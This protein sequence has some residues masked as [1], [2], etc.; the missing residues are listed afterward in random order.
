MTKLPRG[1]MVLLAL[2]TL[3]PTT[4]ASTLVLKSGGRISGEITHTPD[5]TRRVFE[6]KTSSGAV[7][8][9]AE[10]KVREV[11]DPK[12]ALPQYEEWLTKMP[13]TAAGNWKM[14]DLCKQN[15]LSEERLHH[16]RKVIELDPEH[17]EARFLLG[18]KK[19][20]NGVWENPDEQWTSMGYRKVGN[21]FLS[22]QQIALEAQQKQFEEQRDRLRKEINSLNVKAK[23]NKNH[24]QAIAD[25]RALEDPIAL[26][27]IVANFLTTRPGNIQSN[28]VPSPELKKIYIEVVAKK[29]TPYSVQALVNLVLNDPSGDVRDF[30]LGQLVEKKHPL[31]GSVFLNR[32]HDGNKGNNPEIV[33]NS[34]R[35]LGRLGAQEAVLPL[36][37]ALNMKVITESGGG[38]GGI[39]ASPTF[40]S[41]GSAGLSAGGKK[42]KVEYN[43]QNAGVLD[44]LRQLTKQDYGYNTVAWKNWY[45]N[46]HTPN[47]QNMR[48]DE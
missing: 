36:I 7:V 41:D 19:L 6:V 2:S 21:R 20:A 14:A 13:A 27:V 47:A 11:L 35:A 16:L 30:A 32:I 37:A 29:L 8:S 46:F 1:I 40:G 5:R 42:A 18:Y 15:E 34:A 4:Y 44:A 22:E 3:P 24:E 25:L 45:I 33:N 12:N 26:D 10:E 31:T 23:G 28:N 39:G 9:V 17:A 43:V 48:R 38:S